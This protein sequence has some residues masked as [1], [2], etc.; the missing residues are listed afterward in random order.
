[1]PWLLYCF[2]SCI[3]D[4]CEC[5]LSFLYMNL[6][7]FSVNFCL[8]L[9]LGTMRL[10]CFFPTCCYFAFESRASAVCLWIQSQCP[11]LTDQLLLSFL[12]IQFMALCC[13]SWNMETQARPHILVLISALPSVTV[14][15]PSLLVRLG[16]A[17]ILMSS[18]CGEVHVEL[19][20]CCCCCPQKVFFLHFSVCQTLIHHPQM[21]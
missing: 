1:M 8:L 4:E 18:F 13:I 7:D 2:Y 17:V 12:W 5:L 3:I 11:S 20:L 14:G 16:L 15:H 19:L 10:K 21:R 9:F 6:S